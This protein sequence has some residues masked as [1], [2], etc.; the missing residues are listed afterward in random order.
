MEEPIRIEGLRELNRRLRTLDKEAPKGLRLAGNEAAEL[1]VDKAKPKIPIGPGIGGHASSSIRASSTR[2]S[3]R[4]S[5][6]SKRYPYYAWLDFGGRVGRRKAT[7]RPFLK[8]GR[9]VWKAFAEER[10]Q[11]E[12]VLTKALD[13]VV[14]SAG[15]DVE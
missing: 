14:T 3:A 1:I 9:Y 2:T 12:R 8:T 5:A 7:T 10:D 6:G 15:L 13:D 4:V 11:V